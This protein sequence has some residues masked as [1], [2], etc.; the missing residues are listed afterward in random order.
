MGAQ[1]LTVLTFNTRGLRDYNKRNNL[2]FGSR[3]K[4]LT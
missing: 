3:K 1:S 2:F 4:A